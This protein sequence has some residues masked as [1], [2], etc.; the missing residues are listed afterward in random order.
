MIKKFETLQELPRFDTETQREQIVSEKMRPIDLL[1]RVTTNLLV[2][3]KCDKAKHNK[4]SC[5]C[6]I[7]LLCVC[8]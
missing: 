7:A 4:M 3:T 1:D 2:S 5:A 6:N 8:V